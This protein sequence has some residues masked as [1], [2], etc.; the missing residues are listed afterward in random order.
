MKTKRNRRIVASHMWLHQLTQASFSKG[1]LMIIIILTSVYD[2]SMVRRWSSGKI[3]H[4]GPKG[5]RFEF[6]WVTNEFF[7][8][9]FQFLQKFFVDIQV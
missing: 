5:T 6:D 3:V 9:V 1:S 4:Y 2:F 7:H 8:K